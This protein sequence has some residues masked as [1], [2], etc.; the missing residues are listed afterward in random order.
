M[1]YD[2]AIAALG[3][4]VR[5]KDELPSLCIIAKAGFLKGQCTWCS[6]P[7][8]QLHSKDSPSMC[9]PMLGTWLWPPKNS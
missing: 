9:Q 8:D 2:V 5:V 1:L 6:S 7:E 4:T 3:K